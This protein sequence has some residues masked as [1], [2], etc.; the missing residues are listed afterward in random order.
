MVE[1][2]RLRLLQVLLELEGFEAK[3]QLFC[4]VLTFFGFL[5]PKTS[6][7]RRLNALK[8]WSQLA[9]E[10]GQGICMNLFM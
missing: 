6:W 7:G 3:A 4:L 5:A 2:P 8:T 1:P 10:G 9:D